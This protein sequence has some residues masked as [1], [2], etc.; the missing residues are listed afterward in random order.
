[1]PSF[2]ATYI[3]CDNPYPRIRRFSTISGVSSS[4]FIVSSRPRYIRSHSKRLR[5]GDS[6]APVDGMH[7]EHASCKRR[8]GAALEEVESAVLPG[9]FHI[10]RRADLLLERDPQ[11]YGIDDLRVLHRRH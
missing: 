2:A 9:T 8:D 5:P 1:M 10:H 3:A 6:T 4:C 7:V 11:P